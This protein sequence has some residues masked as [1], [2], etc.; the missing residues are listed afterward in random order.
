ML[1]CTMIKKEK[2]EKKS[3]SFLSLLFFFFL[4][5]QKEL[6]SVASELSARQEESE[7]S[8]KHLIELRREFKKNVPEVQYSCCYRINSVGMQI[9]LRSNYILKI[10]DISD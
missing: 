3:F 6:N 4:L 2:E 5:F 8:H 1:F 10:I 7:H 9:F